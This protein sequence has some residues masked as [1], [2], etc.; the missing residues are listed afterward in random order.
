MKISTVAAVAALN[1]FIAT[2]ASALG[3]HLLA[4]RIAEQDKSLFTQAATFQFYHAL[5]LLGL[6]WLMSRGDGTHITGSRSAYA[7][8]LG[9]I[10]FS[11]SL[12]VR[13][14]M[15]PGSLG[16]FHWITPI[17]GLALMAGWGLMA[18]TAYKGR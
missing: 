11:G 12:Y 1:G 3:A 2:A 15:G 9:I 4:S 14:V 13:A 8:I 5:A 17:G 6:A 10:A 18:A 7:F 16:S